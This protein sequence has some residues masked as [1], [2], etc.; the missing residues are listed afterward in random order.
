M[1]YCFFLIL[2]LGAAPNLLGQSRVA[3]EP[4]LMAAGLRGATLAGS[5][6]RGVF[7]NRWNRLVVENNSRLASV[8]GAKVYLNDVVTWDGRG[9]TIAPVDW[10]E[11]LGFRWTA[12]FPPPRRGPPVVLLDPGHGGVDKGAV[13]ARRVEE[14]RV[15]LDVARRVARLLQAQG[16]MVHLTRDRDVTLSLESRVGIAQRVRP[17][18]FVSLHVN[19]APSNPSVRGVETFVLTAP[20]YVSTAGG[21]QDSTVYPGH[22]YGGLS[23][24]L[25]HE[26]QRGMIRHAKVE[27]RGVKRARFLLLKHVPAPTVLVELGFLTN[28]VE[29]AA[30]IERE[31]REMLAEGVARGVLSYL[32]AA[33]RPAVAQTDSGSR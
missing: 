29:E 6:A 4:Y 19:S 5:P 8:N 11:G 27:D 23:M 17:D 26:I 14:K 10:A 2:A 12:R 9:W 22:R 13:S 20:G 28:P 32:A 3:L 15:T 25:A 18:V 30:L 1:G 24:L 7:T 33:A 21:K 31:H 16:V